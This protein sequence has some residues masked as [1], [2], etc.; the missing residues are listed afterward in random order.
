MC[1]GSIVC[2][3]RFTVILMDV[4]DWSVSKMTN[5]R[6][7]KILAEMEKDIREVSSDDC[8][9]MNC[10]DC[11]KL[12]LCKCIEAVDAFERNSD[13]TLIDLLME[14]NEYGNKKGI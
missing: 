10:L 5:E 7:F 13:K 3:I 12:A 8:Q 14:L 9:R 2:N 6:Y 11:T 1:G 4:H